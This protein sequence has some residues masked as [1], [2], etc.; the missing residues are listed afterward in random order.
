MTHSEG[1]GHTHTQAHAVSPTWTNTLDT[2]TPTHYSRGDVIASWSYWFTRV[3]D[4]VCQTSTKCRAARKVEQATEHTQWWHCVC[5]CVHMNFNF[6]AL[7][8]KNKCKLYKVF[9]ISVAGSNFLDKFKPV[10]QLVLVKSYLIH[11]PKDC[12]NAVQLF[13]FLCQGPCLVGGVIPSQDICR[14]HYPQ[15][16]KLLHWTTGGSDAQRNSKGRHEEDKQHV[17]NVLIDLKQASINQLCQFITVKY[18]LQETN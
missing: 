2:H 1:E 18:S 13:F 11:F 16:S 7:T 14:W 15:Q 5:S 3:N 4:W 6:T 17:N 12:F 10:L 9:L 8:V